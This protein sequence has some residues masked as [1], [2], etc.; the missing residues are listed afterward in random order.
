LTKLLPKFGASFF[1]TRCR[2]SDNIAISLR[3]GSAAMPYVVR[4][5]IGLLSDSYASCV[6]IGLTVLHLRWSIHHYLKQATTV[7]L[8]STCKEQCLT[9]SSIIH[10]RAFCY[11]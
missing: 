1:G 3:L 8:L 6:Y 5:T 2:W 11:N 4:R 10:K 9:K 7:I